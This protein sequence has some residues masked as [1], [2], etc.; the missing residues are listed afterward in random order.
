M[1]ILGVGHQE[2]SLD[3]W[4]EHS[5]RK[6][7]REFC[8]DVGQGSNATQDN[9]SFLFANKC[10]GQ[11]M[12]ASNSHIVQVIN[13]C[14]NEF[15]PLFLIKK[16]LFIGVDTYS[17]DDMVK[18]TACPF[19]HIKMTKRDWVKRPCVNGDLTIMRWHEQLLQT[20][21]RDGR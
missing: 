15:D 14:F 1:G 17:D 3:S 20:M 7:H 9:L 18:Y 16:R 6:G 19:D 4:V 12:E 13:R 10:H 21:I 11:A 8:L 2:D 5:V